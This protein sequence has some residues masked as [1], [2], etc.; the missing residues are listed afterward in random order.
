PAPANAAPPE[1]VSPVPAE[2]QASDDTIVVTGSRLATGFNT[3][4]PVA[5]IGEARLQQRGAANVADV[6]NEV[7]SFR[8]TNTPAGGELRPNAGYVGGRILD[9]RGLGSVRTLTLVDGK[10]FVPSTGEGTVDTNMIPS[11]LLNRA[12]VVTGGASAQYGS[13]AVAGVVNLILNHKLE[14]LRASANQSITKYGDGADTTLGL[15]GGFS[16]IEGLHIVIGGEWEH[17]E[18]IGDCQARPSCRTEVINVGRNP[19]DFS[20]P[21]NNILANVHPSTV[22][23]NGV[24]IPV[25]FTGSTPTLGPVG[26][27]TFNP[28]GTP[29]HFEF[30]TLVNNLWMQGGEGKGETI[31][32]QDFFNSAPLERYAITGNAEWEVSPSLTASLMVNY[33]HLDSQY[34]GSRY[35]NTG[36]VIHADNPFIPRSSDPTLDIPTLLAANHLTSFKLGKGYE[37]LG[38]VPIHMKNEVFRTVAG[39]QGDIGKWNWDAYYQYGKNNFRSVTSNNPITSRILRALDVTTNGAGQPVCRVN[40]DANT[41]ND[42]PAC[43]PYNPF[44]QQASAQAKAYV[45]GTA[46]QTTDTTE[47][48]VGANIRGNL[49]KLPYG[50]LALA[51][52]GEFRSDK[53]A[54]TADPLSQH[55][56]FFSTNASALSGKIEVAEGYAEANLPLLEGLP[57]ANELSLNGAVRRTHYSRSS[58]FSDSST[59]NVTTYKY[60]AV[61]E[62]FEWVRFRATQ[63]RDIRAPNITELFGP[64]TLA[65]GILN[66][67]FRGGQQTNPNIRGGSNPDLVPERADTFTAG[68]VLKPRGGFLGRFRASVDYYD[69]SI[70]DAI[71][72]LGQQNIV[73][74]CFQGDDFA[75]TLFTRDASSGLIV[76]VND[77]LQNVNRLI[78]RGVDFELDY[79]QPLGGMGNLD[80]RLLGTYVKDFITVDTVGAVDRA[81]Q[82]GLRGGFPQGLPDWTFDAMLSWSYQAFTLNGHARYINKG[83]YNSAFIGPNDPDFSLTGPKG[84]FSSN[85]NSVPSKT[86]IDMLA[87]YRVSYGPEREFTFYV[88]VDNIFNT[89]PVQVPGAHGTGNNILFNPAGRTFKAGLR[90]SY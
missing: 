12:E 17:S 24:T 54:G 88:G 67:P 64:N 32:F 18:G 83:F 76:E 40:A 69:I 9:L 45:T 52:G 89:W 7:P 58:A 44:G 42:D 66:D 43:V 20:R 74:R 8:A 81:G 51:I 61:F 53:L 11:I 25:A 50:E 39:L 14:G 29:R 70:D 13:D 37:E 2:P 63:S 33:G 30:G 85:T 38:R 86:Y 56:A 47:H 10:R 71:A 28:D 57:F 31:Y 60:G 84:V 34:S 3:P 55:L 16:P 5:V 77:V 80:A 41:A 19:G 35:R 48:V 68:I 75:C 82:T 79:R 65:A 46:T 62:P 23:F 87:Q 26:G 4:T 72:T 73:N 36:V 90:V 6:L 59:V 49:I 1:D 21:A 15:A 78:T 27:I 22:P